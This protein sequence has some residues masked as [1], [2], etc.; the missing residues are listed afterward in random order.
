MTMVKKAVGNQIAAAEFKAKCLQI[1][2]R[3]ARG[4]QVVVVTKR[5]KP[6]VRIA[7]I[8]EVESETIFGCLA[9]H[10]QIVGDVEG[11]V[12]PADLWGGS[13]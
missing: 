1:M 2:E 5:G 13:K 11:S 9:D 7:P 3:V 6:M 4:K 8:D 12:L 10:Y